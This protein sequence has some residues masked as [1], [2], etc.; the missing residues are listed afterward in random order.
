MMYR[1]VHQEGLEDFLQLNLLATEQQLWAGQG[2][3]LWPWALQLFQQLQL[4]ALQPDLVSSM[5]LHGSGDGHQGHHNSI[6]FR[7]CPGWDFHEI[8]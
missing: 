5:A 1:D 6:S 7:N 2:A 8:S 3:T 4:D